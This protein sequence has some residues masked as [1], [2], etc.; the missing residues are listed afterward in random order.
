MPLPR[1]STPAVPDTAR[2]ELVAAV[3]A[4]MIST[5]V[6]REARVAKVAAALA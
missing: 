4:R 1:P 5:R 6:E 2:P 3:R